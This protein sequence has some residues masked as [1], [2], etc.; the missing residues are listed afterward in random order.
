MSIYEPEENEF[1]MEDY[2]MTQSPYELIER[3]F[4]NAKAYIL[5]ASHKSG[6]NLWVNISYL[7]CAKN[8]LMFFLKFY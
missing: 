1:L 5:N 3:D 8:L 6:M 4:I 7:N 2:G